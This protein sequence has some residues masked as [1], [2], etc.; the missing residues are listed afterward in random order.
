MKELTQRQQNVLVFITGYINVHGYAPT[1]R[2][3]A[4]HFEVSVKGAY[5]HVAALK[6]KGHIAGG[7]RSRTITIVRQE[8]DAADDAFERVPLLGIVAAGAPILAEE[9]WNGT[10]PVHRSMLKKRGK[11]FALKVRGD[12]MEGAGIM[13]GDTAIIEKRDMVNNGEIAIVMVDDDEARTVKRF[14]RESNRVRLQPENAK[15]SPI[16][17]RNVRVLGRVA[18]VIRSY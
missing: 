9:N 8:E 14:F 5:D 18:H 1:I 4:D 2:E 7:E 17:S 12:S 16:Y 10:I 13:D 6:K 15:Y 3:I 11:Y